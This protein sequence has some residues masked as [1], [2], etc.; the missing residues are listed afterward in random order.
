MNKSPSKN[1]KYF[2]LF[3]LVFF[4]IV[5]FIIVNRVNQSDKISDKFEKLLKSSGY[6]F[7]GVVVN[8]EKIEREG[9]YICMKNIDNKIKSNSLFF[10]D[11]LVSSIDQT[12][13]IKHIGVISFTKKGSNEIL[14]VQ[15]GDIIHY[16]VKNDN[17]YKIYRN[18]E[19]IYSYKATI[20]KSV[21]D[22]N[23]QD[24]ICE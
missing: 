16:N 19:L 9:G 1:I 11:R 12:N 23:L 4:G 6:S 21:F 15:K 18:N 22:V 2:I 24:Y 7:K 13:S 14:N 17:N 5:Y 20:G 8:L 3:L 10:M